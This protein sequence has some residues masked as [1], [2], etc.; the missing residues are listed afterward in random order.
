MNHLSVIVLVGG[1]AQNSLNKQLYNE[2]VKHNTTSLTFQS[3]DIASLPFYSQDIEN[4]PP[5]SVVQLK[6][7]VQQA[8]AV[9]LITPEYNRSFPGVLK[10]ALDWCSRPYGQDSWQGKPAGIMGAS[11]GKIGTAIAQQQLRTVCNFLDMQLMNQPEFYLDAS[12]AMDENG[13]FPASVKFLQRYLSSF[14]DWIE[15]QHQQFK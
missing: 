8:D 6:Q 12:T 2:V 7:T 4:N 3:F 13:L 9:L 5:E 11:P 10:N 14:Q 1:I 15:K